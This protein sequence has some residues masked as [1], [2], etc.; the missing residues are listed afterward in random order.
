MGKHLQMHSHGL[1]NLRLGRSVLPLGMVVTKVFDIFKPEHFNNIVNMNS[2][3]NDLLR[4]TERIRKIEAAIGELSSEPI[5]PKLNH[6]QKT[7]ETLSHDNQPIGE[8]FH[9]CML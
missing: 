9:K 3:R 7:L 4:L 1:G 6:V 5:L 2:S 8:F